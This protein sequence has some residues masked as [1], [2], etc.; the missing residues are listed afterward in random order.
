MDK[1]ELVI[2]VFVFQGNEDNVKTLH[3]LTHKDSV[4]I[5]AGPVSQ[6]IIAL[7]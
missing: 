4:Y 7:T 5:H 1:R 2:E 3:P 6:T